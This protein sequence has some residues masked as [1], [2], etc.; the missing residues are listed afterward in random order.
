V[1]PDGPAE[2]VEWDPTAAA[3]ADEETP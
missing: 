3:P 1:V 2:A